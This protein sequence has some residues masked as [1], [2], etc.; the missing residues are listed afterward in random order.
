MAIRA[1]A[2]LLYRHI[3]L[4]FGRS[5]VQ[6]VPVKYD[7]GGWLPGHHETANL[8][9]RPNLVLTPQQWQYVSTLAK[10]DKN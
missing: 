2:R 9:K 7:L 3:T 5:P 6:A 1:V 10:P 8:T 4:R